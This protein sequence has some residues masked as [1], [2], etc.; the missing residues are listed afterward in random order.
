VARAGAQCDSGAA[1]RYKP[2]RLTRSGSIALRVPL[3]HPYSVLDHVPAG[4]LF[5]DYNF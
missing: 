3:N 5:L 1:E 2:A 4:G